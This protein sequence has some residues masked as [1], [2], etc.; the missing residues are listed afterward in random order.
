MNKY[1]TGD[2]VKLKNGTICKIIDY[3]KQVL[4][5]DKPYI[6]ENNGVRLNMIVTNDMIEER[7]K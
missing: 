3:Y 1:K 7:I 6:V 2:I 4:D 5:E